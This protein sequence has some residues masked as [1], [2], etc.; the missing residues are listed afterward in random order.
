MRA[1][2]YARYSSDNQR[3]A[4]IE[5]Q[6]RLCRIRAEREGWT[7]LEMFNDRARSGASLLRPGLQALLADAVRGRFEL[8]LTESLDRLSRDQ[9]NIAGLYKRL[10]FANVRIVTLAE[11]EIS[12][13]HIGLKGTMG[14]LYLKDLADKTRRGLRGRV[15]AGRSAGGLPYGYA[16]ALDDDGERGGRIVAE[17]E[18]AVV[19]RIVNAYANGK[20]PIAIAHALNREGVPG[21]RGATWGPS[22][23]YGNPKRSNGILHNEIY[24]GRLV[25]NRLHMVKD[26]ETGRRLSRLNPESEWIV[27]DLPHLRIV[28]QEVW[29]RAQDRLQANALRPSLP[30]S[31]HLISKRRA[32]HLLSGLLS[33]GVCGGGVTIVSSRRLGCEAARRR[34]TCTN[35]LTIRREALEQVVLDGLRKHLLEPTL[36]EEF[37][38]EYTREVNRLRSEAKADIEGALAELRKIDRELDRAVQ[39]ILDGVP[40][41][42]IRD[43]IAALEDRKTTLEADVAAAEAPDK[44]LLHPRMADVYRAKI[45]K[46]NEA[47]NNETSRDETVEAIR[48]LIDQVILTP[49][50]D[51]LQITLRGVLPAIIAFAADKKPVRNQPEADFLTGALS[52]VAG[53]R[54]QRYRTPFVI[55]L[56]AA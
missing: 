44:P 1:A 46:L 41:S 36:F 9:E 37:C 52:L 35:H 40:T 30:S 28:A 55:D 17:A 3:D 27:H 6:I 43:K 42:K 39:A 13:L 14:A 26:P 12:E 10:C 21:P 11:G 5:D 29:D 2:I 23:I 48:Q 25:W 50:D 7:I 8:I 38:K 54:Y 20:S 31:N 34:G 32:R 53:E 4:S 24:V 56:W 15:E 33:C 22:T 45:G 16:V 51:H 18:A 49:K 19:R 47:I